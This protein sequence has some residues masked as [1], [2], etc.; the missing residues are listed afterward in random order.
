[1]ADSRASID[2]P[3]V[4]GLALIML[5]LMTMWHEIGGHAA[6]CAA[7]G[8]RIV[9]IGAFYVDCDGLS[10]FPRLAVSCAGVAVNIVLALVAYGLWRRARNDWAR[11][12]LWLLFLSQGF[13]ASGYFAF[14]GLIGVGDLAPGEHGG[15]GIVPY[16]LALRVAETV[17]GAIV[18]SRL[19]RFGINSLGDMLGR[20]E[21]TAPARRALCHTYYL[22]CG[23]AAVLVGLFNP[24]GL[25]ILL[26]SA[27]ASSF[28]GLAGFISIGFNVPHGDGVRGFVIERKL[29]VLAVGF[30]VTLGFAA[31]L[32]PSVQF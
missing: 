20:S 10:G 14:S 27:A 32:G 15:L 28:G 26:A 8:G 21:A 7:L 24:L 19:I 9:A 17:L 18:Y 30:L 11:V 5:P 1:M 31:G 29:W 12:V 6:T 3:S 23:V 25:F 2:R 16:P 13:V 22:T 4:A